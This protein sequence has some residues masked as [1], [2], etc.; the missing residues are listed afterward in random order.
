[1]RDNIQKA[2]ILT[3]DMLTLVPPLLVT[4]V[5][6][7]NEKLHDPNRST[8]DESGVNE[9]RELTYYRPILVYGN[10]LH[11]AMKGLVGN[12]AQKQP[13]Q[14]GQHLFSEQQRQ[15]PQ[16]VQVRQQTPQYQVQQPQPDPRQIQ[17]QPQMTLPQQQQ[18]QQP[19]Y[20]QQQY[21][22]HPWQEKTGAYAYGMHGGS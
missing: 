13:Q 2:V 22:H 15:Q 19:H 6:Q 3:K 10:Q 17:Q 16:H 20:Q 14:Q 11:V 18:G 9:C 21:H 7:Y 4:T 1:M 5:P 12:T 8:W